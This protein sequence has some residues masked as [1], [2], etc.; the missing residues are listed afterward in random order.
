MLFLIWIVV[1]IVVAADAMAIAAGA[2]FVSPVKTESRRLAVGRPSVNG[3][4]EYARR[5]PSVLVPRGCCPGDSLSN[6][7]GNR[8]YTG[9]GINSSNNDFLP[10]PRAFPPCLPHLLRDSE[11]IKL[12]DGASEFSDTE[13][14]PSHEGRSIGFPHRDPSEKIVLAVDIDEVLGNFVSAINQFIADRYSSHHSVSEYHVY[15]FAKIWNCSKDEANIRVHEFFDSP[16]FKT[17]IHPIPGAQQALENLS[18][19]CN[20]SIVT[21]RQYAIQD[22]TIQWIET[23]FPGLF[24][25]IHFGNHFALNGKS[26]SKSEICRSLGAEVLIDDN[27][28]YAIECAEAGIKVLLFD[29]ENS[30]PW[31]KTELVNGHPLVTR[32]HNWGEVEL[33]FA[34]WTLPSNNN[35]NPN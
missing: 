9:G 29:Y 3:R 24:Q 4:V 5:S 23:H 19:V 27:P 15:E 2:S 17:A 18:K 11:E 30:Y 22:H 8:I 10:T 25:K 26:I 28:T 1:I 14:G 16:Y 34:S 6:A 31:S 33:Q 35:A 20:M 13:S 12:G 7:A 21:S 32:V